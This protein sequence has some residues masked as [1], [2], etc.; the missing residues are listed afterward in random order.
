MPP[1]TTRRMKRSRGRSP[2]ERVLTRNA[3][4]TAALVVVLST[5]TT[6]GANPIDTAGPVRPVDPPIRIDGSG[7]QR[8][9]AAT[10][11]LSEAE[12]ALDA[13]PERAEELALEVVRA[14]ATALGSGAALR[15]LAEAAFSQQR[16]SEVEELGERYVVLLPAGD[17]RVVR[18][19]LLAGDA[20]L[21]DGRPTDALGWWLEIPNDADS[22]LMA[23]ALQ[24][25]ETVVSD[26]PVDELQVILDGAR[27]T[28]LISPIAA[29]LALERYIEGNRDLAARLGQ[30]ALD[31]GARGGS[32]RI[33]TG[34][35][36]GDLSEFV[37]APRIGVV[38]PTS[39]SP[40]LRDFAAGIM[41]GVQ[42][43]VDQYG[44]GA[45][46]RLA[47]ELIQRDNR[48]VLGNGRRIIAELEREGA[49]G[50]IGPLQEELVE[51]AAEARS[52]PISIVSPTSPV[53]PEGVTGVYSLQAAEAGA[54]RAIAEYAADRG[55]E[56]A[57]V[58]YP[59][60]LEAAR[61]AD[62]FR[63][64]FGRL[65][66][67]ILREIRY[68]RGT[69]YFADEMRAAASLEPDV[70]VFPIPASDVELL[71]PQ[72]TFFGLD[73]LGIQVLGTNGWTEPGV[74]A[75]VDARHT[76]GVIAA[77]PQ[78]A[79]GVYEGATDFRAAYESHFSNTLRSTVPAYGYDAA[80][81]LLEVIDAGARTPQAVAT[82]LSS[83]ENVEGATGRLSVDNGR[84]TRSHYVVCIQEQHPEDLPEG[85]RPQWTLFPPLPDPE[86]DSIPEGATPRIVGFRCPDAP[87][88]F[89]ALDDLIFHPDSAFLRPSAVET[90]TSGV[91]GTR[92]NTAKSDGRGIENIL[93]SPRRRRIPR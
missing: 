86:T 79:L 62:A 91:S 29:R 46:T 44:K 76:N 14:H 49:L 9:A 90:D 84:L 41:Q 57:V 35:V 33:A 42:V 27:Q 39:G 61:E 21:S 83:L 6:V 58:I 92:P 25:V 60:V 30:V 80:R 64:A 72:V 54:A 2:T 8:D 34:A 5:C 93:V 24:R 16:W 63:D 22:A 50:I 77:A 10:R 23:S 32:A 47:V 36:A 13:D 19:R 67:T 4:A 37:F 78:P 18:V 71:A 7:P 52:T 81:V 26:A 75:R 74:L 85:G 3:I 82:A 43:A 70:V 1:L 87:R 65:G 51:E 15:I 56:T 69:T 48:G 66:G 68:P 88:P 12:A 17:D 53:V 31:A 20:A 40:R 59:D 73:S 11:L 38:L 28:R 89:G 45:G 55:I